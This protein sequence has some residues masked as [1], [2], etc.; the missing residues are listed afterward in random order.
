VRS[1]FDGLQA[2]L[3]SLYKP[4]SSVVKDKGKQLK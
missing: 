4:G 1:P 3:Y 2:G